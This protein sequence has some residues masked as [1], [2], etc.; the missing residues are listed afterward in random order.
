[1]SRLSRWIAVPILGLLLVAILP[2][3]AHAWGPG[4]HVFLGLEVL[5]SLNLLPASVATLISGH[6]AEFLYGTVAA[7]IPVGKR[8]APAER[9][10][11]AWHVGREMYDEAGSDPGLRAAALG[12]LAHLAAD[13]AAHQIFVPRML[14]LTSSTKGVGH[15]YW[16]HRMDGELSPMH[17][18]VARSVVLEMDHRHADDLMDRVLDRTLFSFSANRRIFHGMVRMLDD[19]RWQT[20][21][22]ALLD[23]SRWELGEADSRRFLR[24]TFGLVTGFLR[25]GD[26][27]HA[28]RGDPTGEVEL[29]RAK[30]IRR[31]ILRREGLAAQPVLE[32]AAER[33]F[34]VPGEGAPGW[35]L[36]ELRGESRQVSDSTRRWLTDPEP[37][38]L[39][40]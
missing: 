31:R 3:P 34:P 1:M 21:F 28:V 20:F 9:H 36:W 32:E 29:A 40:V 19:D 6:A 39:A 24:Y 10:P 38:R 7:D 15:S 14:L 30:R 25:D 11:H 13:V 5:A 8:Y 22:D 4:T 17:I 23:V 2:E 12:Y 16:E 18:R 26:D 35:E 27:S 37:R 33:H